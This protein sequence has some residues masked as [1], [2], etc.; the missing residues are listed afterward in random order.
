MKT[1]YIIKELW[2]DDLENRNSWGYT[3]EYA[4]PSEEEAKRICNTGTLIPRSKHHGFL[5]D[6]PMYIYSSLTYL[7]N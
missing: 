2:W 4:V 6:M 3:S 5:E 7:D 1:I